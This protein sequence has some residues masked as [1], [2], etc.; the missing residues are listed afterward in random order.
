MPHGRQQESGGGGVD[1]TAL[2]THPEDQDTQRLSPELNS[3][4]VSVSV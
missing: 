2:V 3:V 1:G 4:C